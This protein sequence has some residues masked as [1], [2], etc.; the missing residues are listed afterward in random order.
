VR[1]YLDTLTATFVVRQLQ[2]WFENLGKRQVK[3]PKAYITDSGLL[4]TLLGIRD[5]RAL[6]AHPKLG[7]SWEGVVVGQIIQ[8]LGA[9]PEE[10]FFWATHQGAELDLLVVRGSRRLGF[11][12]KRTSA[13]QMTK[14]MRIAF[15]DLKLDRL[16]VIH[17]GQAIFPIGDRGRAVA[18]RRMLLDTKPLG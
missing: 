3:A 8:H 15:A 17:A 7:A 4:H 18:A 2:P 6:D 10:C 1:H 16:D 11:E 13:P 9:A 12:V 5:A 14:S